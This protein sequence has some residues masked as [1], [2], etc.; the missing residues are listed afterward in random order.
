MN[1]ETDRRILLRSIAIFYTKQETPVFACFD[2][3]NRSLQVASTDGL[4]EEWNLISEDTY[5]H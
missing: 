1:H 4:F 2:N 5:L 3:H